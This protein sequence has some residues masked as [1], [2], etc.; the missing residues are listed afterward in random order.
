MEIKE[1]IAPLLRWWWLVLAATLVAAV[2]SYVAAQ[3][4]PLVYE[5]RTTLMSGRTIDDPNP[6]TGQ[7][8]LAQQ[9]AET[10]A[11]IAKRDQIRRATADALGLDTLPQYN[12]STVPNTQLLEIRVV[13][14]VPER[15]QAV[16]QE[17]ANQLILLS[18]ASSV[19]DQDRL[20]FIN[21]QL[22]DLENQI[23]QTT[24]DIND[25][26]TQLAELNSASDIQDTKTQIG[27]L[28]NKLSSL[29]TIYSNLLANTQQG[30]LNTLTI[31]EPANL[32]RRPIGP[33]VLT[34]VLLASAIGLALSGGAAY[35]LEYL[36]DSLKTPEEARRLLGAPVLGYI[37]EMPEDQERWSYVAEHPRSAIAEAFRA[38]RT[39]LEF[40][41]PDG[42]VRSILVSSASSDDG[43]SSVATNLAIA[44]AQAGKKVI[45]IDAD[46]RRPSIHRALD[47]PDKEGLSDVLQRDVFVGDV[48]R[49]WQNDEVSV[50][51]GGTVTELAAELLASPKL[52]QVIATLH[53]MTDVLIIDGPP[54]FIAEAVVLA[55]K[56]DGV[57][58]VLR[59]GQ[60]S[61]KLASNVREQMVRTGAQLLGIV[62]NRIPMN[63][64]AVL[65][66]YRHYSPYYDRSYYA[67]EPETKGKTG[68]MG[69]SAAPQSILNRLMPGRRKRM[70]Q[71]TRVKVSANRRRARRSS[72][73]SL[74]ANQAAGAPSTNGKQRAAFLEWQ[75]Q[76][77]KSR[78]F[79]L[80]EGD[81]V[82][83]GRDRIND[84]VLDS[85]HVSRRHA[86]IACR[87]QTVEIADLGSTN[88]TAINGQKIE[89]PRVLQEGDVIRLFDV[90]LVFHWKSDKAMRGSETGL[91]GAS[92][93]KS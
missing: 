69:A 59:P 42:P 9:L 63:H 6:T 61:K 8:S 86:V 15:A 4:Q 37:A 84:L 2:S 71:P 87:N 33:N 53:E 56:A 24:A 80:R 38:L 48:I 70:S 52:E 45:L 73:G 85:R 39:N 58:F 44:L 66:N 30:A 11:D 93:S 5:S 21:D 62:Y 91:K 17:L 83:I 13:D 76:N 29:Q 57:L 35:L 82:L 90:E 23:N 75:D 46:L 26:Q 22:D 68:P 74:A 65:G 18:P 27:A 77:G 41:G 92:I 79:L 78:E 32:P 34:T 14:T 31:I 55:S 43:K 60:T 54:F 12:V 89:R 51:T 72:T 88:G 28:Q 67:P 64:A 25:L 47:L 49:S 40:V 20:T 50:I 1:Y 7:L 10:Y 16:A 19:E 81:T 3:R 36:D